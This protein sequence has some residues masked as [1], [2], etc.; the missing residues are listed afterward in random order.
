M[1]ALDLIVRPVF[2][3]LKHVGLERVLRYFD[4]NLARM[5]AT[6]VGGQLVS[7]IAESAAVRTQF[8]GSA[9][10][11]DAAL[12]YQ[13]GQ[14]DALDALV[15]KMG[16]EL[17]K[18]YEGAIR[19]AFG[20]DSD[21]YRA[22]FP[23]GLTEYGAA[24]RETSPV[25]LDRLSKAATTHAADLAPAVVTALKGYQTGWEKIR[26]DQLEGIGETGE[27]DERVQAARTAVYGQLYLTLHYLCYVLKG[28]EAAIL[29]YF[30]D[31]IVA[32]RRQP[33]ADEPTPS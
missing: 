16:R 6:D 15:E 4:T 17:G 28:D 10:A 29:H 9:T 30:D 20:Q 24:T 32:Q 11:A 19:G 18:R 27:A 5:R 23:N 7:R 2:E 22:F 1:F 25:L 33:K 12:I 21:A 31:S 3:A 26:K 13:T 8:F 14:T